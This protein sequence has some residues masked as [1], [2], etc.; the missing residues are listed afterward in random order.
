[1]VGVYALRLTESDQQLFTWDAFDAGPNGIPGAGS[2]GLNSQYAATN[3]ALY[4]SLDADV[5]P[6]TTVSGGLRLEQRVADYSDSADAQTP[7]PKVTNHMIG[8][9]LSWTRS[10]GEGEHVY[11][12]LARG[13]KGGGFN[14]GSGILSEQ[15]E[16]GPESLWSLETGLKYAQGSS[17]L[18][19]Q[20]DVFYMRRQNMQVYLSEQLQ[21]NN[22]LNYVF[23]TQNASNGENYGLEAEAAYR[24]NSHWHISG[25]GSLLRTRYL[26]VI[27]LFS[28][29]GTGWARATVRARL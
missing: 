16:F 28:S 27:G 3:V 18:Q 15:R 2:S 17:P 1:M 4:G 20:T 9:N 21:Q 6:R 19:L 22:P 25:S 24:L 13:Y 29:A 14:I 23:Y 11:V 5:G 26:D 8:G 7:F 10:T 12:T